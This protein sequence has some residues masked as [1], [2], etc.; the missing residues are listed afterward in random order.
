MNETRNERPQARMG[1][2]GLARPPPCEE[3]E[4]LRNYRY[5]SVRRFNRRR[6]GKFRNIHVLLKHS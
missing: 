5:T 1:A 3:M 6:I 4:L 2:R